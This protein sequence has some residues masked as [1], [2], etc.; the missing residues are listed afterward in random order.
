[1]AGEGAAT[2]AAEGRYRPDR[3][4]LVRAEPADHCAPAGYDLGVLVL[5]RPLVD[6]DADLTNV[7]ARGWVGHRSQRLALARPEKGLFGDG[8]PQRAV[9]Q[10][11][12]DISANDPADAVYLVPFNDAHGAQPSRGRYELRRSAGDLHRW[13][14]GRGHKGCIQRL[15]ARPFKALAVPKD[16]RP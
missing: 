9:G 1:M 3:K 10:S 6:G 16:V 15:S 12:A 13:T 7:E 11:L 4:Q 14:W 2:Q 5:G 8:F